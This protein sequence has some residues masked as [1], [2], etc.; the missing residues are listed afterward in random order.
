MSFH[1]FADTFEAGSGSEAVTVA[2]DLLLRLHASTLV[3]WV[4]TFFFGFTAVL[5]LAAHSDGRFPVWFVWMPWVGAAAALASVV[6]TLAERQWTTL[7][8]MG[9]FR[10]SATLLV[11]WLLVATWWMRRGSVAPSA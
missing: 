2:A 6:V 11:L 9:L 3:A 5:G 1:A 7:S 4:V 8:E 10:T